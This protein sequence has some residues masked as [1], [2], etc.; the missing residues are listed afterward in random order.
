[1]I[2]MKWLTWWP[3][4]NKIWNHKSKNSLKQYNN[5]PKQLSISPNNKP[6]ASHPTLHKWY[7]SARSSS[8]FLNPKLL[9]T[10]KQRPTIWRSI[11][12][13]NKHSLMKLK[14]IYRKDLI[15]WISSFYYKN[16]LRL[17]LQRPIMVILDLRR[18]LIQMCQRHWRLSH[19]CFHN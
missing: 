13:F 10:S 17:K 16:N 18:N 11:L 1:M 5:I 8:S 9:I 12:V 3:R 15:Y 4:S 14:G 7:V 2:K 6:L 19:Q